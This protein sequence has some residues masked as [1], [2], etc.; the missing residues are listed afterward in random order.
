MERQYNCFLLK[1]LHSS[2]SKSFGHWG[3]AT[4]QQPLVAELSVKSLE[5]ETTSRE[6]A[7]G[8]H[9]ALP[10]LLH[11]VCEMLGGAEELEALPNRGLNE[12]KKA[13]WV[14]YSFCLARLAI[15]ASSQVQSTGCC[16]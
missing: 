11:E 13:L 4:A 1:P 7:P 3:E 16:R 8:A 9:V 5:P 14:C 6:A 10:P 15:K 12:L 2:S